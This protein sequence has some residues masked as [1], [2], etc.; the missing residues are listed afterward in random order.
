M[1]PHGNLNIQKRMTY[2]RKGNKVRKY[3]TLVYY[4]NILKCNCLNENN[5]NFCVLYISCKRYDNIKT[6]WGKYKYSII[7]FSFW[8]WSAKILL[9]VYC[10]NL[11][12]YTVNPNANT[13]IIKQRIIT[14]KTTRR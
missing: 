11:K 1:I 4:F 12:V 2:I 5:I 3:I 13:K 9:E 7:K 8:M 14:N 6:R 10:D